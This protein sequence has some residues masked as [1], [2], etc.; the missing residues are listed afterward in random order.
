M[1]NRRRVLPPDSLATPE[2]HV[3]YTSFLAPSRFDAVSFDC[4]GTLVDWEAGIV[5]AVRSFFDARD[6]TPP[7]PEDLLARFAQLEPALQK[8]PFRRYRI[9]LRDVAA[10][11]GREF[12]VATTREERDAFADAVGTWPAFEDVPEALRDLSRR[13]RLAVVSNVDD[14]L[15]ARTAAGLG[16]SFDAV[17]TAEQVRSY[18]PA[19]AHFLELMKRLQLPATRILHAAESLYHDV[20]PARELGLTTAWIN[21]RAGT[22]RGGATAPSE[23]RPDHEF[24]DLASLAE[25]LGCRPAEGRGRRSAR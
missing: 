21:R 24:A 10:G 23:A 9:V 16:A 6:L 4:Y 7:P 20:A 12:G 18:K 1:S 14:D 3:S 17:V 19:R 11:L 8:P 13:F 2:I 15:F 22:G 5:A 25:A